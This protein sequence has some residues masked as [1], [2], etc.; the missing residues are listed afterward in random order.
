[1]KERE[2]AF[3][4]D[5]LTLKL[6]QI[7]PTLRDQVLESLRRGSSF[8]DDLGI[9]DQKGLNPEKI[10]IKHWANNQIISVLRFSDGS[11]LGQLSYKFSESLP[12]SMIHSLMKQDCSKVL[13]H[14]IFS[15]YRWKEECDE[16]DRSIDI[17][18]KS[19][20]DLGY[21]PIHEISRLTQTTNKLKEPA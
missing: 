7:I 21:Y 5:A 20:I 6:I 19:N 16:S 11:S 18:L 17:N 9:V 8:M 1:M 15:E 10:E 4:T 2:P 14:P 13:G 3:F 12:V